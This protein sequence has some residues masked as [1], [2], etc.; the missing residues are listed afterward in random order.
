MSA[1]S[2]TPADLR[3]RHIRIEISLLSSHA[4]RC[5]SRSARTLFVDL[6]MDLLSTNNGNINSTLTKLR[7]RGWASS[8]TLSNALVELQAGGFLEKTRAG[9]VSVGSRVCALYAFTDHA[10]LPHPKI[11]IEARPASFAYARRFADL[12]LAAVR[13]AIAAEIARLQPEAAA[14]RKSALERKKSTLRNS[15]R[16]ASEIEAV[17][18]L[19]AS[20]SE[21]VVDSLLRNSKQTRTRKSAAKPRQSLN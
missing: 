21:V 9:G 8:S 5:M 15:K 4:W 11:G 6:R 10:V 16:D 7:H 12:S 13:H 18:A 3:G 14:S 1:A 19:D 2:H 17:K 20:N